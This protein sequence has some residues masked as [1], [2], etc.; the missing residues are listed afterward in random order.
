MSELALSPQ[1]LADDGQ[2]AF[3]AEKYEL[4]SE[5]FSQAETAYRTS[6]DFLSAAEMANNRSVTLLKL[7][8]AQ[9]AWEA[10]KDTDQVFA[11]AKDYRRQAMAIGNQASALEAIGEFDQAVEKYRQSADLL[12]QLGDKELRSTVLQSLSALQM[13]R[14]KQLESMAAMQAALEG[15]EKLGVREKFLKKLLNIPFKLINR[16]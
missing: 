14:G 8:D 16:S 5:K 10:A 12:K 2:V 15:K 3:R 11:D 13:R 4:A 7:G 9:G 1:K 6:N